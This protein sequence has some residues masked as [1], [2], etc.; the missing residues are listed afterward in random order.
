MPYR[1]SRLILYEKQ[2]SAPGSSCMRQDYTLF[3]RD[4]IV[5]HSVRQMRR[6]TM[7]R[8]YYI[9]AIFLAIVMALAAGSYLL[10]KRAVVEAAAV[11]APRFEV[12]PMW[13][14]PLPNHWVIG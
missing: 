2:T 10:Q 9:G 4:R 1:S 6:E 12:D 13:P 8:T 14:K 3:P 7:K 5:Y 11:Q